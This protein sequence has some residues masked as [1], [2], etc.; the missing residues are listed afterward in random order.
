MMNDASV[1]LG[2]VFLFFVA[3]IFSTGI[4]TTNWTIVDGPSSQA[5]PESTT[6]KK[7][8]NEIDQLPQMNETNNLLVAT[9][10]LANKWGE[11][12]SEQPGTFQQVR[13]KEWCFM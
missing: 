2:L 11:N 1:G 6:G 4:F 9:D 7:G 8:W 3:I 13:R 5:A 10:V 12:G